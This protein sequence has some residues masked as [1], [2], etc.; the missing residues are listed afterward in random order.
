MPHST[1]PNTINTK[2]QCGDWRDDLF[3]DGFAVI[4]NAVSAEKAQHYISCMHQWLES[5]PYGFDRNAQ[6]TWTPQYLPAHMKGG[7]YHGYSIQHEK[8][9]WE[10]RQEPGVLEAF[11]RLWE[12]QDLLVSFDGMNI[13]L[14][15]GTPT[16]TSPWPHVDQSPKRRGLQCVQGILNLAPNGPDDGGLL[17]YAGSHALN[18]EFFGTHDVQDR[19]TWGPGDWFGFEQSEVDWFKQ[20]GC[21][22]RKVCAEPGDLIVWDSRTVHFNETPRSQNLRAVIYLCYTP[23][24]F[25][26]EEDL[27]RKAELFHKRKGTTHWPHANIFENDP[28]RMRLGK[29]DSY[30]RERPVQEPHITPLLLKLA[31]ET[32]VTKT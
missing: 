19:P 26:K 15:A 22:L 29:S 16:K 4:K 23:T 18:E 31:G 2:T 13:T 12:T 1:I 25:A 28:E 7:M 27:Q 9:M 8:F 14:P 5:F 30:H 17:V 20:R 6:E 10:A 11:A 3:R 32:D 24:A 21:E